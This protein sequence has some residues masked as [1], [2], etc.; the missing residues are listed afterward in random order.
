MHSKNLGF[1]SDINGLRA[2]AVIAVV[3]YHFGVPG[4]TGGFAG[5]DI[6]FVISGFLMTGIIFRQT[7][8]SNFSLIG[9]YLARAKRIV[10]ALAV[11]CMVLLGSGWFLLIPSDFKELGKHVASSIGFLSNVMYWKEVGYFDT[12]S[13][14]KWLLHTWSLSVEWQ[15]YIIYPLIILAARKVFSFNTTRLLL[16]SVGV[17]SFALCLYASMRSPNA[18]FYLLPA[19]AWEMIAGGIIYLYPVQLKDSYQKLASFIGLI[20]IV[21]AIFAFTKTDVWPGWRALIPVLG[22]VLVIYGADQKS[23]VINNNFAGW[24]GEASYSIYLWHWP[25]VVL[26]G[27]YGLSGDITVMLAG[28]AISIVLGSLSLKFVEKPARNP[29]VSMSH[30]RYLCCYFALV[31]LVAIAGVV[32]YVMNGIPGR[33]AI[34]DRADFAQYFENSAPEWAYFKSHKIPEIYRYDCDFYDM[35]SFFAGRATNE[36]HSRIAPTCYTPTTKSVVMVWGDSHAQQL[37]FGLKQDLPRDISLLQVASSGCVANIPDPQLPNNKYCDRS[38]SVAL[39]VI[40]NVSP[41]ILVIAQLASHDLTNNLGALVQKAKQYGVKHVIVVGPV[42]RYNTALYKIMIRKYWGDMPKRINEY[43]APDVFPTDARLKARSHDAGFE[44]ISAVDAFCNS[45]G[46]ITYLG[47][48]HKT[49][50]V[51]FDYGHLTSQASEFFARTTLVPAILKNF[52]DQ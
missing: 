5:V 46:C 48:D 41:Q 30:V 45:E 20:M 2:I 32:P 15:F 14:E 50:L 29:K 51:T 11:L 18:A 27:Y 4:F 28:I 38:N 35:D 1:R 10:P 19:R 44:Y 43:F 25:I 34:A 42:P 12:A 39:D 26:V 36:P 40:K 6:F 22:T 16:I 49:G 9:F 33:A 13:H 47:Q 52:K 8:S 31:S 3:L 23:I 24:I 7:D 21:F 37:L 17:G